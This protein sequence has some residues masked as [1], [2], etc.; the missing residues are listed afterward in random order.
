MTR[1]SFF[2]GQSHSSRSRRLRLAAIALGISVGTLIAIDSASAQTTWA[3]PTSGTWSDST[4]WSTNVVP[5]NVAENVLIDQTGTYTVTLD[6]NRS[7]NNLTLNAADAT[8]SHTSGTLSLNGA[9]SVTAGRYELS[10]GTIEGGMVVGSELA[11]L[12]GTLKGVSVTGDLNLSESGSSV[13][14]AGGT[15]I[16]GDVTVDNYSTLSL[17]Q[18]HAFSNQTMTLGEAGGASSGTLYVATGG[19]MNVDNTATVNLKSGNLYLQG[20][21]VNDGTILADEATSVSIDDFGGGVFTNTGTVTSTN[22]AN[23]SINSANTTNTGTMSA[24]VGSTLDLGGTWSNVGGT[25]AVDDTS[26]LNLDGSF[27]TADL[28][29]INLTPGGTVNITGNQNNTG[30]TF[31]GVSGWKLNGGTITG[32]SL[33]GT[34]L[35][36]VGGTLNGVAVTSDLNLTDPSGYLSLAGGT[37]IAGDV[38]INNNSTLYLEQVHNFSNQTVTVGEAGGAS[39]GTLYVATGGGMNVDNTATANLKSGNLY[40]QG[41][42]VNDG[43]IL[44]D[45]ATFVS[46]DD[47]GGGAITNTGTV[48]STNGA[49]LS[50]NSANTTNTG[51]MSA[52]VGSTL[53]LGGTWSNVGGTLA[54]DDTSTLNLGGSFN[55][56][57]LGTINL[58][59]GGTIN[60]TG[61]QN[62]TGSTFAGA[63]G[64]KLNGG[65]ITGGSLDGTSL[66]VIG[67]TLSGVAVTGDLNLTESGGYLSVAGGTT[68][69]GDIDVNNYSTLY[70][71]QVQTFSNQTVTVGDAGGASSGTVYVLPGGSMNVDNTATVN[72]KAGS[73]YLQGA[74]VNDGTILADEATSVSVDDFG[75]GVFTNTA[76]V[77]STN[78][79]NLSINSANTTNTGTMSATLGSTLQLG[80]TWSN[81]GGTLAVDDTSTLNLGGSFNTTGLGTINLT[82]GGTVNITGSQNNAGS[83][84]VGATGWKLNGGTIT[85]GTL[86]GT[87]LPFVGGTLNGVAVNGDLNLTESGGY[88]SL[89]GGTTIAG[90]IDVNNYSTLYLEQGHTF[91]NQTVT[92]GEAG[93]ASAGTLYATADGNDLRFASDSILDGNGTLTSYTEPVYLD[94]AISPGFSAGSLQF[95]GD[96]EFILGSTAMLNIELGGVNSGELDTITANKLTLGGGL[97]VSLINGFTLADGMEFNFLFVSDPLSGTGMFSGLNDMD[98]VATFGGFDLNIAYNVGD[99]NDVRLFSTVTAIPEP[100]SIMVLALGSIAG[101]GYRK[102]RKTRAQE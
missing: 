30:S 31:V 53:D 28:G 39:S 43:T 22:G 70:L 38:A 21:L 5:D 62:N 55:T 47:F 23:L 7:I 56:A 74:L 89:A 1:S 68:I 87:S 79:A 9:I 90:D 20:A 73:L 96:S 57:D 40:L 13:G 86:D 65:T 25:L 37:T 82:P 45:E 88:L 29:T 77:T 64:W 84:F 69:A 46:V 91:S 58:T 8:L 67:G 97:N 85:G 98:R 92:L 61:T 16:A 54:V 2:A 72:L 48:T 50:I 34:S 10:N 35:P 51:T 100:S 19:G 81:L 95:D 78:G 14:L 60:I 102:R 26:T 71:E 32:G 80:G 42:L 11:Y 49:N 41:A 18:V 63:A 99:G 52:T 75:G 76:T 3:F 36:F 15:T 94:G 12:G 27:N 101:L 93:G 4:K 24:T 44:A 33:D 66:P 59:P 83:T 6:D 17:E